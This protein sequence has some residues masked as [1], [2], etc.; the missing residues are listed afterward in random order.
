MS[1]LFTSYTHYQ[2]PRF[3]FQLLFCRFSSLLSCF[4]FHF[5]SLSVFP[6]ISCTHFIHFSSFINCDTNWIVKNKQ[7]LFCMDLSAGLFCLLTVAKLWLDNHNLGEG[8]S[9]WSALRWLTS[10][11]PGS[12]S[13]RWRPQMSCFDLNSKIFPKMK[14]ET[15]KYSRLRRYEKLLF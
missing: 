9:K 13:P 4:T 11:H 7:F 15:R 8:L 6:S 1:N 14:V 5:L 3:L 10:F 12:E 2:D